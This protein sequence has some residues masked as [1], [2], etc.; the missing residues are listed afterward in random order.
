MDSIYK[1]KL[2]QVGKR[3]VVLIESW[4]ILEENLGGKRKGE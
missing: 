3:R 2:W 1:N 4:A